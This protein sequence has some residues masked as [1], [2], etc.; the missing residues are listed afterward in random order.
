MKKVNKAMVLLATLSP[1]ALV[2]TQA[3][4]FTYDAAYTGSQDLEQMNILLGQIV[5]WIDG[6]LG[7]ILAVAALTV[8]LGMGIM[9]QSIGAAIIG[10]GFAAA[11]NYGPEIIQG[12][13]GA[14]SSFL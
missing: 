10:I 11:V 13:S 3:L 14:A 8:G 12:I 4:A 2:G 1:L 7:S 9:Q 5:S 6:P